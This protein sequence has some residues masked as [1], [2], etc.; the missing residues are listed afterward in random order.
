MKNFFRNV[1]YGVMG[2]VAVVPILIAALFV[3]FTIVNLTKYVPERQPV[4]ELFLKEEDPTFLIYSSL[5]ASVFGPFIEEL[6][7]RAFMYN[8]IKKKT[9]VF[10]A[11]I[12]TSSVFAALHSNVV[13]FLPIMILGIVLAYLYEKTGTIISSITVHIIHNLSMVYLVFLV[14]QLIR[15]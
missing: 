15:H 11:I 8:A 12:I 7:F 5:F 10:W 2:Y 13:G 14:K 3:V 9:G 1:F 4:V 6:F